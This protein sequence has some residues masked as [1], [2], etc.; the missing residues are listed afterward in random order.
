MHDDEDERKYCAFL[1]INLDPH[2]LIQGPL[3]PLQEAI[4]CKQINWGGKDPWITITGT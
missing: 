2:F 1:Y 4:C 3:L